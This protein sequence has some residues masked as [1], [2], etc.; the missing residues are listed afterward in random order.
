[1]ID[2]TGYR[3][4]P[5]PVWNL[6]AADRTRESSIIS[7]QRENLDVRHLT[8]YRHEFQVTLLRCSFLWILVS[9]YG[10]FQKFHVVFWLVF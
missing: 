8:E 4:I 2:L 1:M 9:D 6:S 10:N 3:L 5:M 7:Y